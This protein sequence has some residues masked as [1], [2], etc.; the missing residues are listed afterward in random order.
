MAPMTQ[1]T[2]AP[3]KTPTPR[4]LTGI[5]EEAVSKIL[6]VGRTTKVAAR[7]MILTGGEEAKHLFLLSGG[8]VRYYRTTKS[9]TEVLL[10]WLIPGDVFGLGTLLRNPP[11]YLGSARAVTECE[12][13]VWDHERIRKLAESYPRLAEN[14]LRI[15][16]EYMGVLCRRQVSLVS[17]SAEQRLA[18]SLLGLGHRTGTVHS[19]GVDVHITNE[20]L[21]DL[22]NTTLFTASRLLR[23]WQKAGAVSKKRGK[24]IIHAPE[25]LVMD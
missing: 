3:A 4:L 23:K 11:A 18:D 6:A 20:Q 5:E 1:S 16:F 9:G 15:V 21:G 24:V 22:A 10:S 19:D 2:A 25:A 7:Q 17:R 8:A 12:L 13:T 14:S